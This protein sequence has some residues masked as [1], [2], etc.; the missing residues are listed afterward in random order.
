VTRENDRGE[1]GEREEK[2]EGERGEIEKSRR[3]SECV[4]V[5]V[6]EQAW[7]PLQVTA[8][9]SIPRT[10][11]AIYSAFSAPNHNWSSSAVTFKGSSDM[12]LMDRSLTL[13]NRTLRF[14]LPNRTP[15]RG[16]L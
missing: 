3:D 1:T 11:F 6:S 12:E 4:P 15:N 16:I 7:V 14:S 10:T 5:K 8:S 2:R 13:A 9:L